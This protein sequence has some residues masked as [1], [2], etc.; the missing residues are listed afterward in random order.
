MIIDKKKYKNEISLII[1]A[2]NLYGGEMSISNKPYEIARYKSINGALIF[3]QYRSGAG[4]YNIRTKISKMT[5][6]KLVDVVLFLMN[7]ENNYSFKVKNIGLWT[8][9]QIKKSLIDQYL[10]K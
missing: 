6:S 5:D 8:D 10:K 9:R 3:Y 2:V 7:Y 1:K 4:N